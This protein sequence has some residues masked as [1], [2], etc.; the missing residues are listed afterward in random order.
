MEPS[1][2]P[3][4]LTTAIPDRYRDERDSVLRILARWEE[5]LRAASLPLPPHS[6]GT[7]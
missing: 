3:G 5:A 7:R 2:I 6:L 1:R 4:K